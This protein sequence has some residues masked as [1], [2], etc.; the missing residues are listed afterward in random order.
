MSFKSSVKEAAGFIKEEAGEMLGSCQIA[1]E[2]RKLRNKARKESGKSI[3]RTR[4]GGNACS[5]K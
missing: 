3:I 5:V 1:K 2:G 4:V